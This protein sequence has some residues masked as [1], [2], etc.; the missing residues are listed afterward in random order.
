[1]VFQSPVG[2]QSVVFSVC[3]LQIKTMNQSP[4]LSL[5]MD[6]WDNHIWD[7]DCVVVGCFFF[8][9]DLQTVFPNGYNILHPVSRLCEVPFLSHPYQQLL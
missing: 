3:L 1:M 6:I 5:H 2:K 8:S 4:S 9:K 7:C